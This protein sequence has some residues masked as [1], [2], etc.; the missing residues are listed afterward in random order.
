L[1]KQAGNAAAEKVQE[2]TERG[3][4]EVNKNTAMDSENTVGTRVQATKDA[5]GNKWNEKVHK[6]NKED[7]Q[8]QS[9]I[10]GVVEGIKNAFGATCEKVQE[11]VSGTKYEANKSAAQNP[12][13][14]LG[15]RAQ[16]AYDAMGNKV[17]EKVHEVKGNQQADRAGITT[18]N[19]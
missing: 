8:E 15:T 13:N 18:E 7:Y 9:G 3:K 14:S 5:V 12:D 10:T 2:L 6:S 17:S 19:P 4:Y 11:T 1:V 16:A